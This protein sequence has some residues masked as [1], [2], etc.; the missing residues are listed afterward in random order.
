M[1]GHDG[2]FRVEQENERDKRAFFV[3][4]FLKSFLR[5]V[6]DNTYFGVL[7]KLFLFLNLVFYVFLFLYLFFYK[8]TVF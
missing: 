7:I 8:K 2:G 4:V 1:W 6:F 3:I 5:I